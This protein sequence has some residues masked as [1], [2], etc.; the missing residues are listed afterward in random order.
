[1]DFIKRLTNQSPPPPEKKKP[2]GNYKKVEEWD[3]E[4]TAKGELTWEERVQ[5]EGQQFGN[6]VRQNDILQRNLHTF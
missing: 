1:M 5:F 4:R 6:Q 3:A 2:V